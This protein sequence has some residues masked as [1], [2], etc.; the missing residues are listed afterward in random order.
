MTDV[1]SNRCADMKC[2]HY[3]FRKIETL[4]LSKTLDIVNYLLKPAL[5]PCAFVH[6]HVMTGPM[7]SVSF[8]SFRLPT[9][10]RNRVK[11]LAATRGETVQ[12][13]LRHM[14]EDRL[15]HFALNGDHGDTG[16]EIDQGQ[17]YS[18]NLPA[19]HDINAK[20][21]GKRLPLNSAAN[22]DSDPGVGDSPD[23]IGDLRQQEMEL[24]AK[25]ILHLWQCR[26]NSSATQPEFMV[27]FL[28][29]QAP[30]VAGFFKLKAELADII[31]YSITLIDEAN[32]RAAARIKALEDAVQIF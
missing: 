3:N 24:R 15:G 32:I 27:S 2:S 17:N 8:L 7:A 4:V 25:G 10:L 16:A 1:A 29:R 9:E 23:W 11:A 31:G 22:A 5:I 19:G 28:P 26:G 12:S 18:L 30:T 13:F 21:I 14:V 6:I 20:E